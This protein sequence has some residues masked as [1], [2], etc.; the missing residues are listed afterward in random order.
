VK[1]RADPNS[2]MWDR[3]DHDLG[4]IVDNFPIENLGL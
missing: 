2:P 3:L 4:D 1:D